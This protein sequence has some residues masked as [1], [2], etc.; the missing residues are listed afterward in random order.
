MAAK[1]KN[2]QAA[3]DREYGKNTSLHMENQRLL[4]ENRRLN[5]Q[6]R[7]VYELLAEAL[8][9]IKQHHT[10]RG[11]GLIGEAMVELKTVRNP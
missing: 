10:V 5:D 4:L 11:M 2:L 1:V 3:V 8:V 7:S 6:R 9:E